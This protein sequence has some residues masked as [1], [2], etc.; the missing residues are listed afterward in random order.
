MRFGC[1]CFAS[2]CRFSVP[3]FEKSFLTLRPLILLALWPWHPTPDQIALLRE[4]ARRAVWH[5]PKSRD[6][7]RE[8]VLVSFLL[9]HDLFKLK[10]L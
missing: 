2:A 3:V 4:I 9:F 10:R 6:E 8:L 5:L 7:A 1:C